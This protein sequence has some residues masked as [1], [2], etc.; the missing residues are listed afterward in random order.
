M[1]LHPPHEARESIC[2]AFEAC[3]PTPEAAQAPMITWAWL[4][5]FSKQSDSGGVLI[6]QW[7][8]VGGSWCRDPSRGHLGSVVAHFLFDHIYS[9]SCSYTLSMKLGR[10]YVLCLKLAFI[11]QREPRPPMIT[12]DWLHSVWKKMILVGLWPTSE[13]WSGGS[14]CRDGSRDQLGSVVA[15]FFFI[16]FIH[17]HARSPSPWSWGEHMCCIWSLHSC[18]RGCPGPPWSHR[19]DWIFF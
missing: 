14:Q 6:N 19:L 4:I 18:P 3:I 11:P 17:L 1:L 16:T 15:Y 7:A 12:W 10:A 9:P 5:F 13:P 8:L 2:V